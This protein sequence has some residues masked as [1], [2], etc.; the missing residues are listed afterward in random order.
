MGYI[1]FRNARVAIRKEACIVE[2]QKDWSLT[3]GERQTGKDLSQIRVDHKNRYMYAVEF[4]RDKKHSF[5]LD[6]FCG[7]GYG[8]YL[9]SLELGNVSI[10]GIDGSK[11][12]ICFANKYYQNSNVFYSKKEFPFSLPS[13]TFDF[14]I[15]MESV[16]HVE[17]GEKMITE[18]LKSLKIGGY[19]IFSVP[20][21]DINPLELNKKDFLFHFKHYTLEEMEKILAGKVK[22]IN[23]FGQNVYHQNEKLLSGGLLN[24]SEM[25]LQEKEMGQ[26]LVVVCQK[27]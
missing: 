8:T 13:E 18:M 23:W 11:D 26:V 12:A 9:L 19:F 17:D 14:V 5:G 20:N 16:E 1:K 21:E 25:V 7:T 22:I 4:L 24:E 15:S 6:C 2:V 27:Y 10:C 3:S